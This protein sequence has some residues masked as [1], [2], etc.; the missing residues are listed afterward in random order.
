M[1]LNLEGDVFEIRGGC[2]CKKRGMF[3]EKHPDVFEIRWGCLWKKIG[4]FSEKAPHLLENGYR[5]GLMHALLY[6]HYGRNS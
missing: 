6:F 2:N 3:F 4:M 1:F 5:N